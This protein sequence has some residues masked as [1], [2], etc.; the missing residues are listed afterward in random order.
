MLWILFAVAA[1]FSL[2]LLSSLFALVSTRVPVVRTPP[3]VLP[4]I[5]QAF[6]AL[7]GQVLVD[8][9]CADGRTLRALCT[10]SGAVGRGYELNG[11]VWLVGL[12]RAVLSRE[13]RR[14]RVRLYW[15]DFYRCELEGAAGVYCFLMPHVMQRIGRKCA[16]EMRPGTLLVSYL[17]E[18]PGW[19]P[20]SIV[21]LGPREDPIFVYKIPAVTPQPPV[22]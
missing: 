8:A 14:A 13:R 22:G 18:V 7:P 9:G 2:G 1:L 16:E 6:G 19:V 11:P 5:A 12:L 21:K 4:A 15:R 17:W 3:E 10:A 20:H